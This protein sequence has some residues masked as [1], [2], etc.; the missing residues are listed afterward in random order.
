MI[1]INELKLTTGTSRRSLL[2]GAA[3]LGAA[4]PLVAAGAMAAGK[5]SQAAVA[6]QGS[7]KGAQN[8]ANCKLFEK[9]SAC[10][11]VEG[12]VSPNGWC[13]IWAKG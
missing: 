1:M 7:P 10:K 3:V 9:P 11:L 6:Y 5:M 13:R 8:C 2:Q 4:V 12:T